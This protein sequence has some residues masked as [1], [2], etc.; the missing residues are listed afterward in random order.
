MTSDSASTASTPHHSNAGEKGERAGSRTANGQAGVDHRRATTGA[1][2]TVDLA[3]GDWVFIADRAGG[4]K[5]VALDA[6]T[7]HVRPAGQP[8]ELD[9]VRTD[10]MR[11]HA[12]MH[13]ERTLPERQREAL[14]SLR[15]LGTWPDKGWVVRDRTTTRSAL[16]RLAQ[17]GLAFEDR[18]SPGRFTAVPPQTDPPAFVGPLLKGLYPCRHSASGGGEDG[19]HGQCRLDRIGRA[20]SAGR[21]P[22]DEVSKA[23]MC[24]QV[25][26]SVPDEAP[27]RLYL[28]MVRYT[29][30]IPDCG[31][32]SPPAAP[33]EERRLPGRPRP[34]AEV[35]EEYHQA[36]AEA[37]SRFKPDV[38]GP[39]QQL[40]L[41]MRYPPS[42][43]LWR[44]RLL[45]SCGC[46][47]ERLTHDA[48]TA[49]VRHRQEDVYTGEKLLPGQLACGQHDDPEPYRTVLEYISWTELTFPADTGDEMPAALRRDEPETKA[50][51][52]VR[53]CCGH[54]ATQVTDLSWRPGDG[55][56][57]RGDFDSPRRRAVARRRIETAADILGTLEREH[58]HRM[59]DLGRPEP[60]P[61]VT[62]R[63]C[64]RAKA[65]VA[66]QRVGPLVP[67]PKPPRAAA[68]KQPGKSAL[69]RRLR[70][71]EA[72]AA[73]LREQPGQLDQARPRPN[74]DE[75]WPGRR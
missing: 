41:D 30:S 3:V 35:L 13:V 61:E 70:E 56:P 74:R 39:L 49:P 75:P 20:I 64:P 67:P 36:R 43:T 28:T 16:R 38:P 9:L 7:A 29:C 33:A 57:P 54:I 55:F 58:H 4:W 37:R 12:T 6:E 50:W 8:D 2:A 40:L 5:I 25:S 52:K 21:V 42:E 22:M 62:C 24:R 68:G 45:L 48:D 32:G 26:A 31:C 60:A 44:W 63:S 10:G 17:R 18:R 66:Y 14:D 23:A 19:V 46:S 69:A 47:T 71:V 59:I 53:L 1:A 65:I 72:E 34:A 27:D 51:W 73:R 11:F 15:L